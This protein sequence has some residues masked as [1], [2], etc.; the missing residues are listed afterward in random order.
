[1]KTMKIL[2]VIPARGGSKGIPKKNLARLRNLPL[3]GYSIKAAMSSKMFEDI[4]VSTD[5]P[6]IMKVSAE[7]GAQTP[8]IRP[9]NL[10]SDSALSAPVVEH[11]LLEMESQK[12]YK[13]DAIMLLQPT[14]PLRTDQHIRSAI[15]IFINHECDSVVSVTSVG[16]NHPLRMKKILPDGRLENYVEQGFWNLRPRQELP[17]IFIR[18]GAIYLIKREAF[19]Q[20]KSLIANNCFAYEMSANDSVNID[21]ELDLMLAEQLLIRRQNHEN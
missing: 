16:G 15:D 20:E 14:S 7:I 18:N 9:S 13:Y 5:D 2:A 10:A 19:L 1:M 8:F 6:E 17:P 11:A 12:N 21:S 4:V 3:I